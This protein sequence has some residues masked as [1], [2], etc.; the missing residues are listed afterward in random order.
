MS[1]S[2]K[3]DTRSSLRAVRSIF[4][5]LPPPDAPLAAGSFRAELTGPAW[6]RLLAPAALSLLGFHGWAG[7]RIEADG[8]GVN[9]ARRGGR[10]VPFA[11]MRIRLETSRLDQRPAWVL[12]YPA[13]ARFPQPHM[14]D[15]FRQLDQR[16][17]LGLSF[18]DLPG[19]CGMALPF[20][21]IRVAGSDLR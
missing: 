17:L 7:K 11:P 1:A 12:R 18:T 4:M 16:T 21:L 8:N 5:Q 14:A 19:L 9:L 3:P 20:L 6:V 2:T 10:V 15:E 13:N